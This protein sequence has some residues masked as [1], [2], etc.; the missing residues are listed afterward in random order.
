MLFILAI[1]GLTL[2]FG[3]TGFIVNQGQW[4]KSILF[5]ADFSEGKLYI[6]ENGLNYNLCDLDALHELVERHHQV[7]YPYEKKADWDL[8]GHCLKMSFVGAKLSAEKVTPS[9]KTSTYYNYYLGKDRNKWQGKVPAYQSIQFDDIYPFVDLAI[10]NSGNNFKYDLIVHKNGDVNQIKLAYEGATSLKITDGNLYIKTSVNEIIEQQPYAYQIING[11]KIEVPCSFKLSDNQVSYA[12]PEGYNSHYPLVIDPFIVFS[13]YSSSSANN[14]GYTATYD[15]EGNAYGAGSVFDIGYVTTP[16]AFD[17]SFNGASTDIGITKYTSDGLE[18]IYASYLGGGETDLPHSIVVNSQDELFVLGTTGSTNFPVSI[19]AFDTSFAGGTLSNLQQ[20][21]GVIYNNGTD[22]IISKF[23]VDGSNLL[24]STYLGGSLNDGLNLS[25]ALKYNY[26]DEVRGEIFID[27]NDDC[28]V[29]SCTYSLDFP[30]NN[31]FQSSSGGGLDAVV[32]KMNSNLSNLTWSTYLGGNT[33]D[34]AYS[35]SL[36]NTQNI[37][38]AGGTQSVNF[39]TVNALQANY[40]G[41]NADGFITK[42]HSAGSN[43]LQSTYYG[44]SAYDQIYFIDNN[45]DDD[46]FVFGQTMGPS[47]DLIQNAS[48]AKPNGGQL[49]TKFN[50]NLSATVWSTRFGDESGIPDISPTAFLVDVCNQ[51]FLSGWGGP[52]LGGNTNLSG[53]AGLDVT[54]D[55]LDPT[56]DNA[57]FYFMVLRDDASSLIYAS[58]FGGQ[59]SSEH[60]DG[61]TSRFDKKGV[62]YQAVCA[63]C[64][65]NQDFPTVPVDSV[66]FWNNNSSC[67][68]GLVKYAFTPP[69]ILADFEDPIL[70]CAPV[71]VTFLNQSQTAFDDTSR[72]TFIWTVEDSTIVAFDLAYTFTEPGTYVVKLLAIDSS[73]CNFEDSI[74]KTYIVTGNSSQTLGDL[75]TCNGVGVQIGINPINGNNITYAWTPGTGLSATNISNPEATITQNQTYTLIVSNSGCVDTFVQTVLLEEIN[76]ALSIQDTVCLSD[77]FTVTAT[78]IPGAFYQ[79]EPAGLVESGQGSSSAIFTAENPM[80]IICTVTDQNNCINSASASIFVLDELPDLIVSA[81]PDTVELGDAS[82]L[83]AFSSVLNVYNWDSDTTLSSLTIANPV[84]T[85]M[86]TATYTVRIDDGFCPNKAEVTVYVKLPECIEG[87]LFVPNAFTP[88]GDGN[89]E[90]FYVRSSAPIDNFY[91]TVYDRWGQQV[92][93]TRDQNI[94]W[95]GTFEGKPLS[96]SAFAWYCSGNCEGGEAFFLKGNIS[97]LK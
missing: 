89:N 72:S 79:W 78:S 7:T 36:D 9:K 4:E 70:N 37:L 29:A 59:T 88:N 34:A 17:I 75:T 11:Q 2:S 69:S 5:K 52:N 68:L 83:D 97:I 14:F 46:I 63:G 80:N 87:K 54:S 10:H 76:I 93:E 85:P 21:L 20:G 84:A 90:V 32:F 67:N 74:T 53:T 86:E 45:D 65:G 12:L 47:G 33:D 3:Q 26:A 57:D 60:V 82:Q 73:S 24:A 40:N 41:G 48:Y 62:I 1:H 44:T 71:D 16:G 43:L 61:G 13:R 25:P 91:F 19:T 35:I 18:Q 39:P 81:N 95:D 27:D 42:L 58:F 28:Y 31:A 66:G 49:I 96:P 50:S 64:G 94:G 77:T 56:T 55:A 23:S 22:L 6:E 38:L 30:V 8:Q 51:V 92:F 15:S